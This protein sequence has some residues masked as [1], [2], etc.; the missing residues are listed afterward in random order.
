MKSGLYR[1]VEAGGK[2]RISRS[3]LWDEIEDEISPQICIA[4]QFIVELAT[5][6]LRDEIVSQV[7]VI[8]EEYSNYQM[9]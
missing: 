7:S 4:L 1:D 8:K 2:P 6:S 9:P 3:L 5:A